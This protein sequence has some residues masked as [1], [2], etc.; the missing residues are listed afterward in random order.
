MTDPIQEKIEEL[1]NELHQ[2]NFNYYT[3]DE[4]TI[5]D[6]EFDQKLKELEQL[7]KQHPEFVSQSSP[8]LRVGGEI[9]KNFPTV[10]HQFRMYSLDNSYD[11]N[12]LE[13]WEKRIQKAVDEPVEFVTELKYDGASI[14]ILYENGNLKEAVTRG[15]GFQ[16]DEITP[17]VKTVS[18]IPLQLHGDYPDKFYVRGEIY[19]T[20]KSFE[21][22]NKRR[23]EE[24]LDLFMNP[25]NTASGSLKI[26]DSAEVSKRGL[27]SVLYQFI[28]SE[29]PGETHWELLQKTKSWGF[30]ISEQMKLCKNLDEV[31]EFI[32]FWDTE[33]HQLGFD[34]DGIVVKVNSLSQQ[35]NLGY[36]AKSP[37]WA[38][39]YKFKAEKVETE[40]QKVTYQVGRT[41]AITPVANLKPV[42]LAGTVVKRA[43]LHNEDII[44]KLDLHEHD[45][46][47][48]EKG[49]EIIPKIV[50]VNIE[51]RKAGSSVIQYIT[52]CPECGT[53]L[54]KVEDQAIHFCPNEL[55]CPPQVVGRMIH[56]VSR[57]ALN[58]ENLGSETIEQLYREKLVENPADFYALTK[59]QLLPLE[60]MAEK[61]ARNIIEG[62]EKSKE[63]PFE[64]VLYGI[65]IKHVGETVAK[66][67]AKNFTTIDDLKNATVEELVQVEDIG[68]KIAESIVAFFGNTENILMIERLK[69][70]GVQL[71]KGENTNEL[72]SDILDSKTFLFTGKL[73]LFTREEAEEM[74]EKHGGKNISAVSKNL[75]YLVVGE[76]AGSKLK[77]AQDIG[78][79]VILD[80]QE[81]LELIKK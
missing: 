63:I 36:T 51:K 70:Y 78:T 27:S 15:D 49:G 19:L 11:F 41:G 1:R 35:K 28:S 33:R 81:F 43:S 72:I 74:V 64:K 59:E 77:K 76:K 48:V 58:I 24:G 20:R 2:H 73:S 55:H 38:M 37:R 32:S 57:K 13:D 44:K 80:E 40:L 62:I 45:F 56:Y 21:K 68:V 4:P 22:I 8:T 25:R 9:T 69:S 14:S 10:Q 30:R 53:E 26:Q 42:L 61:S 67:L 6:F 79:I 23:E 12:D 47:F 52:N 16:G 29:I 34:I 39:A 66:K 17:N 75:N 3:L 71:E 5:S 65:G 46:V 18:E 7:E 50:A 54:V 31:K 60:R